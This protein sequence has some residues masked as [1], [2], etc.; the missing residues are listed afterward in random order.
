MSFEKK[1]PARRQPFGVASDYEP[2]LK[3]LAAQVGTL[4]AQLADTA[5]ILTREIGGL[6]SDM[7]D[8]F[9]VVQSEMLLLRQ[10]LANHEPRLAAVEK[11]TAQKVGAGAAIAGKGAAYFT[12]AAAVAKLAARKWPEFGDFFIEL[13]KSLPDLL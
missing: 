11:T 2:T 8:R 5:G 4:S 9:T 10:A 1:P 12:L 7:N 13:A 3:D 6:R